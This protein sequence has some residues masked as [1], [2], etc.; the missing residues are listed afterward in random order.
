MQQEH[1]KYMRMALRLA[2]RGRGHVEPNPIVG[3]VIVRGSKIIG[4]GWH[5]K[6]GGPHAEVNAIA[7]AGGR[8]AGATVYVTLEPCAHFGK[9]PPCAD[10][11]IKNKVKTVVVACRDIF[12]QT[13][14]RGIRKLKTAGIEVIEGILKD[15]AVRINAPFFKR[16]RKGLPYITAKWAMTLDGRIASSSGDSKWISSEAAR[17]HA[18]KLRGVSD[19]IIVGIGTVLADDPELTCRMSRGR[20][21]HRIIL[22]SAARMPLNSK[23]IKT[24]KA[25]PLTI[26]VASLAPAKKVD[27]LIKAGCNVVRFPSSK[28]GLSV[29]HLVRWM[30][31]LGMTNVLVEGGG[32]VLG[33]F[34]DAG[35]I[36]ET[37]IYVGAK[38]IGGNSNIQAPV[39]GHGIMK[40]SM[41]TL[42]SPIETK[43][44]GDTLLIRTVLN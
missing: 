19:A 20:N 1:E 30:G 14:G 5:K 36:D 11:L 43:K 12:P 42:F 18:H 32:K 39:L 40:M 28:N 21:P 37:M 7:N 24:I 15:E 44:L 35:C 8:V 3:C 34:F 13:N 41:A 25:A 23:L 31:K 26:A 2:G 10:L 33:S 6:Y 22:D 16:I 4:K 29:P 17:K 27:A 38:V 9:T